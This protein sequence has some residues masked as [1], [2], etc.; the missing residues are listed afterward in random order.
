MFGKE[1]NRFFAAIALIL[2]A[3]G[4]AFVGLIWWLV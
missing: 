1:L 3:V 4:G 2:M